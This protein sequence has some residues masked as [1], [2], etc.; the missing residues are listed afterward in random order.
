VGSLTI[1]WDFDGTLVDTRQRNYNVVRRLIADSTGR[2][3]DDIP[4]LASP[5]IYDQVNRRYFNW[6]ELYVREFGFS[7]EETDRLGRLWSEYQLQ[8]D[9][10]ADVF[11]GIAEVLIALRQVRHGIVSQ[12][13]R[14][15]I[16]RTLADARLEQHFQAVVGYDDV[17]IKHQKPEPDGVLA[18]LERLRALAPGCALYIGD[19]ETDVR[20]AEN[21]QRALADR[22]VA[23]KVVSVAAC[24]GA[25]AGPGAWTHKPDYV[26]SSPPQVLEIAQR[27][28]L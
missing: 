1:L 28:R 6:R 20:C 26:A 5:E 10:P 13:A 7:E 11:E 25:H 27:C 2:A 22:G 3:L 14:H 17:D 18:C 15:Q 8:D 16:Q 4:A 23:I 12:N 24:F 19:H 9:T 21:A